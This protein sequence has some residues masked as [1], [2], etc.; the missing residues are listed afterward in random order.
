MTAVS[1]L[2]SF[3]FLNDKVSAQ[4]DTEFWFAAPEVSR[5]SGGNTSQDYDRPI[6]L[7]VSSGELAANIEVSIPA[8]DLLLHSFRLEGEAD[9]VLDLTEHIDE[10]ENRPPHLILNNGLRIRSDE[11]ISA[12]YEVMNVKT[13]SLTD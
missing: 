3:F 9:T 1:L 10:L 12:Y 2:S 7:V 4:S 11:L 8:S 6:Q 13:G 5:T